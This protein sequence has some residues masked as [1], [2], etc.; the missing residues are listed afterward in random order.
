MDI[1]YI[2]TIP[3][4]CYILPHNQ[5]SDI[6]LY[7]LVPPTPEDRD[8]AENIHQWAETSKVSLEFWLP[9]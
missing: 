2:I 5:E 6:P 1:N 9:Q 3:L 7:Y 4:P 8:H